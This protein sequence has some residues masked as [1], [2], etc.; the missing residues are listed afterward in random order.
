MKMAGKEA[1]KKAGL[2]GAK[3]LRINTEHSKY[4]Q[5]NCLKQW[6]S[7]V[8][9]SLLMFTGLKNFCASAS[10]FAKQLIPVTWL[11][12]LSAMTVYPSPPVTRK[13][14]R[15]TR[16]HFSWSRS[17]Y[18]GTSH[19]AHLTATLLTRSI[20][21]LFKSNVTFMP[22]IRTTTSLIYTECYKDGIAIIAI[23]LMD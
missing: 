14:Q 11:R 21:G 6:L 20:T 15:A 16:Y 19:S 23:I 3:Q 17:S 13:E 18:W 1:Q 12:A 22:A 9:H 8:S 10:C 4:L 5:Q 2:L 7:I